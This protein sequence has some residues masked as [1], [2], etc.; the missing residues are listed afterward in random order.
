[1]LKPSTIHSLPDL[2]TPLLTIYLDAN[3]TKQVIRGLKPGY[4]TRFESQ[5]KMI[6]ETVPAGDLPVFFE[7]GDI[8]GGELAHVA[9]RPGR[10]VEASRRAARTAAAF[11]QVDLLRVHLL[12]AF[13][14]RDDQLIGGRVV[15]HGVPVVAAL[16][17][18]AALHP[19]AHLILDDIIAE[20][21]LAGDGIE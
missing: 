17:G 11:F 3:P 18:R 9:I 21:R 20:V 7:R 15:A 2:P 6:A 8:V 13:G 5:A 14:H 19:F 4:L 16:G 10:F 12:A 1:M